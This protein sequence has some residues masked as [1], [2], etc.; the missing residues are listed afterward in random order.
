MRLQQKTKN[1]I[2]IGSLCAVSYFG[3]YIARNI[4]SAVTP[5]MVEGGYTEEYIG[6]ISSLYFVFYAVGQLINGAIGD[7]IKAKYVDGVLRLTLPKLEQRLPEGR[8]LEIE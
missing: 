5:Q 7:K 2:M 3:V 8:R 1:A 4:L 6:S